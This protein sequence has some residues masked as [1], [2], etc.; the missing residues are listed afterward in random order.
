MAQNPSTGAASG[1][2][3]DAQKVERMKAGR[4]IT[5]AKMAKLSQE[6]KLGLSIVRQAAK[7]CELVAERIIDQKHVPS[8]VLQACSVLQGSISSMLH[9]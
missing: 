5:S 7:C 2:L 9:D 3:T 1:K 4:A 6:E 8:E